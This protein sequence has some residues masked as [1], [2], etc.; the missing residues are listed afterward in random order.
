MRAWRI[1]RAPYADLRGEGARLHG[2]RWN[3]PGLALVYLSEH[4]AL[5][6]L[7]IL[8]HLDLT[9]DFLPEDYVLVTVEMPNDMATETIDHA[10]PP[11]DMAAFGSTWLMQRR[12][13]L[14]WVP[15]IILP[16]SYNIL[17]NPIHPEA[18]YVRK[19]GQEPLRFDA[20][21]A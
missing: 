16:Q 7:E 20:R 1:C 10:A 18:R 19:I 9:P 21:L 3:D 12:T 2:G 5:S 11:T 13:P 8:V 6:L 4:P 14:L 15:S 17:L